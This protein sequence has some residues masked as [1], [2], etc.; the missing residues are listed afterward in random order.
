[1]TGNET[2]DG[3][4]LPEDAEERRLQIKAAFQRAGDQMARL[5]ALLLAFAFAKRSREDAAGSEIAPVEGTWAEV[6]SPSGPA[7][8][9]STAG[10]KARSM[11]ALSDSQ[12]TPSQPPTLQ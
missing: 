8:V 6:K 10:G 12:P 5:E 4:L 7:G 3:P 2:L 9:A 11:E 1:M